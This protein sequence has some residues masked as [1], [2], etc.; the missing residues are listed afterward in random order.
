[1]GKAASRAVLLGHCH[2]ESSNDAKRDPTTP[3]EVQ[4]R[5]RIFVLYNVQIF[6]LYN[7]Q[8]FVLYNV[9]PASSTTE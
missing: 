2:W 1:M 4:V 3:P 8:I 5:G 9:Q 7:V 6:V